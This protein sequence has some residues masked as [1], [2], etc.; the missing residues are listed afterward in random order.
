ME[1]S[2]FQRLKEIQLFLQVKKLSRTRLA[3][4]KLTKCKHFCAVLC[5][6]PYVQDKEIG[7]E[8]KI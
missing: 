4:Q 1:E 3:K 5:T 2:L 8:D 6:V 7:E